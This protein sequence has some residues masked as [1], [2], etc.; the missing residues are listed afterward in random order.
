M[1][2][3]SVDSDTWHRVRIGPISDLKELNRIRDRLQEADM[4]YLVIRLGD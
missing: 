1:Q 2:R 3:I 4:D